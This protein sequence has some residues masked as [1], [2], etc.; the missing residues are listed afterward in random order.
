MLTQHTRT[1]HRTHT[2]ARAQIG[3]DLSVLGMRFPVPRSAGPD[4]ADTYLLVR[5]DAP[6]LAYGS[7]VATYNITWDYRDNSNAT[8]RPL[9]HTRATAHTLPHLRTIEHTHHRTHPPTHPPTHTHT[10]QKQAKW[11]T[12]L[13]ARAAGPW[14]ELA[15]WGSILTPEGIVAYNNTLYQSNGGIARVRS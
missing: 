13:S 11:T 14:V 8:V 9:P 3:F 7:P 2:T 1:H 5:T 15:F 10:R 6:Q 12:K 4:L